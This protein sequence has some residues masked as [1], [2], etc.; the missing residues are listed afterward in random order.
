V[1][2]RGLFY[3]GERLRAIWRLLLFVAL[4]VAGLWVLG[5]AASLITL[6]L[7]R[8]GEL[9]EL[10]IPSIVI[11]LSLLFASAVVMRWVERRPVAGPGRDSA[12]AP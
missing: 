5:T 11:V 8:V 9:W 4:T 1:R 2:V 12:R 3:S 6:R 10:A 7:Q